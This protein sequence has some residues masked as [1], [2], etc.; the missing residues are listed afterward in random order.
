MKLSNETYTEYIEFT[1]KF[2]ENV[3][4]FLHDELTYDGENTFI[5][6]FTRK[7]DTLVTCVMNAINRRI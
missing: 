6:R 1:K 5:K 2:I 7:G 3:R 4:D